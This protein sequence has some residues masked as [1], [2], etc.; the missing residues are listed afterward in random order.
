VQ[1]TNEETVQDIKEEQVLN[2]QDIQ[3]NLGRSWLAYT[4]RCT[5]PFPQ[6]F[7]RATLTFSK[8]LHVYQ[9][10]RQAH[11]YNV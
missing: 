7:K 5:V 9:I 4:L 3:S 10:I 6:Q 11:P 8:C 2:K 1:G